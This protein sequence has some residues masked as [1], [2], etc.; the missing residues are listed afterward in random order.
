MRLIKILGVNA[1]LLFSVTSAFALGGMT[2]SGGDYKAMDWESAWFLGAQPISYCIEIA[3]KEKL[4]LDQAKADFESVVKTWKDYRA[5]RR[6]RQT[7]GQ[8][9]NFN[10]QFETCST[11]TQLKIYVGLSNSETDRGKAL[12]QNPYAFSYRTSYDATTGLGQGYIWLAPSGSIVRLGGTNGFPNWSV[13]STFHGMLLHEMG[14]VYGSGHIDGTIMEA[15]L[16]SKLQSADSPNPYWAAGGK[17]YMTNIDHHRFLLLNWDSRFE[18]KGDVHLDRSGREGARLFELLTGRP[19]KGDIE[20][21]V[22]TEG[23]NLKL[24][25]RDSVGM[26]TFDI[27]LSPESRSSFDLDGQVFRTVRGNVGEGTGPSGYSY[28]TTLKSKSG[29]VFTAVVNFNGSGLGRPIDVSIME[30]AKLTRIFYSDLWRTHG[31]E[32]SK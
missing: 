21:S 7:P 9:L 4:T 32:A 20:A 27:I 16:V 22:V 24:S 19:S 2:S 14:H 11:D 30:K 1:V 17:M 31:I 8:E 29:R 13:P 6:R 28:L 23:G 5:D 10:F 26:E 18:M 15:D 12:Y 3:P 25:Y